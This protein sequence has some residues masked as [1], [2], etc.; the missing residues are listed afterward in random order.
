MAG[1]IKNNKS[2]AFTII[3]ASFIAA[4]F[5]SFLCSLFYNFWLDNIEGT[6]LEN[7]NWHGRITIEK[8][9]MELEKINSFANV[10]KVVINKELSYGQDVVL[11]LY[12][13]NKRTIY[14]DMSVIINTLGLEKDSADYNYQLLSL[15]FIRIPGDKMPRLVMPFYF[16]IVVLVCFSLVLVIYSSFAVSMDSRIHQFGIL[17]SIGATPGQ[18]RA[19][20]IQEAFMLSIVPVATGVIFGIF[21][22][23]ITVRIMTAYTSNFTEGRDFTFMLHPVVVAAAFL[24]S[25]F[26]ILFSAYIPARKL[27]RLLPLEAIKG[28]AGPGLKKAKHSR[29]LSRVFGIEGELA[30][31]ALKAQKKALRTIYISLTLAFSGF[32]IMQC[33]FTLS[34][35][36]TKHT[37]FEAYQDTWDIM[38]TLKNTDIENFSHEE[39][40]KKINGVNDCIIYQKAEAECIIPMKNISQELTL[41]GG[42]KNIA[43]SSI[44]SIKDSYLVKAPVIIMDNESFSEFCTQAGIIPGSYGTVILN[45][46][47]DSAHS[48]FRNPVYIPFIKE[49]IK[50]VTLQNTVRKG[51]NSNNN[52]IEVPV[53][54]CTQKKPLLREEFDKSIYGLV[55]FMPLSLWKEI[56]G[57]TGGTEPDTYI[58]VLA[59]NRTDEKNI[60]ALESQVVQAASN[61]YKT[62]SENRISEKIKNNEIIKGYK[63]VLGAF[64]VLLALIGTAQ[65]FSNTLGFIRQRKREFARYMSI[66]LEPE[67]T[68]KIFFIEAMVITGTPAFISLII[69]VATT[70]LMIKASYIEPLE[71]IKSAPVMPVLIFLFTVFIFTA[72]AYYAGGRKILKINITEALYDDTLI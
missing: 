31:N 16:G 13:Y 56:S 62:E 57:K 43:G 41:A 64:C 10:Q 52:A 36:S 5:L 2:S 17:S 8:D 58:R 53:L 18:I 21:L 40:I 47:W 38:V 34:G 67:R 4:L 29:I 46:I 7:G 55:Q 63:M 60:N 59:D 72:L 71:F 27:S 33:F 26:T 65:V 19:C 12:F 28:T 35:I 70:A 20:L 22:S 66:G 49:D 37:Y 54:A 24:L 25:F 30:G 42:L 44:S 68:R 14:N 69:T 51:K 50:T 15:Y 9:N 23:F 45:S 1:Y 11:D 3:I 6:K 32:M 48:N 61:G 39:E